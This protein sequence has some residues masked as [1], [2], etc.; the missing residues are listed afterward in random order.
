MDL[1]IQKKKEIS[2]FLYSAEHVS[3]LMCLGLKKKVKLRHQVAT[4][5]HYKHLY[6]SDSPVPVSE[7]EE[8]F[9]LT[10][11]MMN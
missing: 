4:L 7:T 9:D 10:E 11:Q 3:F 1:I 6:L 8:Q 5:I 2:G